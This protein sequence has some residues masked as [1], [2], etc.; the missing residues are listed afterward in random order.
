MPSDK[1]KKQ[2]R[3]K[4]LLSPD[5]NS[6]LPDLK[7]ANATMSKEQPQQQQQAS[8]TY[9]YPY[10]QQPVPY[11]Q[12][13]YGSPPPPPVPHIPP[14]PLSSQTPGVAGGE[15]SQTQLSADVVS[16]LFQRLDI[17]DKKLS[18]LES[19][20]SSLTK[21]TDQVNTMNTKVSNMEVQLKTL[22]HSREFDS[23]TLEEMKERQRHIDSMIKEMKKVEDEQK[24]RL[25]DLQCRQMRDNLLFYNI[26][27]V[28]DESD[29][30]CATKL[31]SFFEEKLKI[32]NASD[33][34]LDRV[35]RLG[36]YNPAK[37]RP[38]I[39]KFCFYPDRETVRKAARNLAGTQYS[40]SQQFPKEVMARRKGLIPTLKSLKD[41]GRRAY[42]S[43]DKLYVDGR[44]YTGDLIEPRQQD[45]GQQRGQRR[46]QGH[47]QGHGR[48]NRFQRERVPRAGRSSSR[49]GLD[50][51]AM[52]AEVQG[53]E[54]RD[55]VF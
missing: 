28:R 47:G 34:K 39:A 9:V 20:Q 22:E 36:R 16:K 21:V 45:R 23:Q 2:K 43:V 27:D 40:V 11:G 14:I 25:L 52:E 1:K 44:L 53:N 35:H 24:E 29:D 38:I 48:D 50:N 7:R 32:D 37:T 26:L 3:K 46:D 51:E 33:I 42:I 18:H 17:M 8:A 19:I 54:G 13:Y 4:D 31:Y 49:D 6:E 30:E 15:Q 41:Q 55:D 10:T 5:S 12:P